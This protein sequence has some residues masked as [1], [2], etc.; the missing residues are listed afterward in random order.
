MYAGGSGALKNH[1]LAH[2]FGKKGENILVPM[3]FILILNEESLY[4][5][6]VFIM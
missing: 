6:E 1:W 3:F 2:C 4:N 5:L